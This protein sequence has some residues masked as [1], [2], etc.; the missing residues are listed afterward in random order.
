MK[1]SLVS[2]LVLVILAFTQKVN[3]QTYTQTYK[4][5]CS[6]EIKVA[7]TT[8]INGYATVSFYNQVRV[9]SPLEVQSGATQLWISATYTAYNTLGC[10]TSVVVQQ[11]V[12]ATVQQAASQAA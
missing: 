8:M 4:D 6:G 12:Q 2:L 10:P 11:T 1:K 9:F 3:A 7:T 5:K